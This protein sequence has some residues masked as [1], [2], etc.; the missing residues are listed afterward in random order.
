ML[1]RILAACAF[2]GVAAAAFAAPKA[3]TNTVRGITVVTPVQG[4]GDRVLPPT[5][6]VVPVANTDGSRGFLSIDG[7]NLV[8]T[9]THSGG[10]PVSPAKVTVVAPDAVPAN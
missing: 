6:R 1:K 3:V 5:A 2:A 9:A 4:E 8:F 7:T 10:T